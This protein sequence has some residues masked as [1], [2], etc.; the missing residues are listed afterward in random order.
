MLFCN[1]RSRENL[2][3]LRYGFISDIGIDIIIVTFNDETNK[4]NRERTEARNI[5]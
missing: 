3:T 2:S 4:T 1:S 5:K